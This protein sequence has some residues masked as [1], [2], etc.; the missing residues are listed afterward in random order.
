MIKGN[1]GISYY[2]TIDMDNYT[3]IGDFDNAGA[4]YSVFDR[5]LFFKIHF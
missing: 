1:R 3:R 5:G 4:A 2:Q